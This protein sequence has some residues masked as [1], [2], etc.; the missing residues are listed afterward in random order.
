MAN[1]ATD[2]PPIGH[3]SS[4]LTKNHTNLLIITKWIAY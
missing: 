2:N 1:F 4:L 3:F